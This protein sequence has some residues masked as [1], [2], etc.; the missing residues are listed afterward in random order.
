M[1]PLSET[2][3]GETLFQVPHSKRK[4]G[5]ARQRREAVAV[6]VGDG[7]NAEAGLWGVLWDPEH[8]KGN[9]IP[10]SLTGEPAGSEQTADARVWTSNEL[11]HRRLRGRNYRERTE[12]E[13]EMRIQCW[14]RKD[15]MKHRILVPGEAVCFSMLAAVA[16]T[17]GNPV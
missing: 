13:N 3:P 1:S 15:W 17:N 7:Q 5:Q 11:K 16:T 6:F 8:R 12:M 2:S 10:R 4:R 14:T 9:V